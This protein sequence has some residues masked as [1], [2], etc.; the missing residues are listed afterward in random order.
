MKLKGI[1]PI[2]QHVEKIVLAVVGVVFV[3][4]LAVQFLV[5]PNEVNFEGQNVPPSEVLTRLGTKAS[6]TL[7]AMND[8]DPALPDA[9]SLDLAAAYEARLESAGF[10]ATRVARGG[11]GAPFELAIAQVEEMNG[12]VTPLRLPVATGAMAVSQW[13]TVD[14]FFARATPALQAYLPES[15]P[16]DKVSVSIEAKVNG[17][18]IREALESADEGRRSIPSHWWSQGGE[19][20]I[21][22]LSVEAERQ[23]RNAD[24]SWGPSEPVESI[25][26]TPDVLEAFN[27]G[28]AEGET[29]G[30]DA[31]RASDLLSLADLAKADPSLGAQPVFVPAISGVEWVQ[32]SKVSERQVRLGVEADIGRVEREIETINEEIARIQDRMAAAGA[33]RTA[34]SNRPQSSPQSGLIIGGGGG[35]QGNTNRANRPDPLKQRIDAKQA[36]IAEREAELDDLF[37]KL[38]DLGGPL[39][40]QSGQPRRQTPPAGGGGGARVLGGPTGA[41]SGP[42]VLGGDPTPGRSTS[43]ARGSRTRTPVSRQAGAESPGP[44]LSLDDYSVWVHDFAA[45]PGAVYRYRVRYGV[46]NPLFKRERSLGS[47][48]P[49]M[50]ALAEEPLVQS[51]W[52]SWTEPAQVG[53]SSYFFVTNARDQGILGQSSSAATAEVYRMFY[54]YYRKHTLSLEPGDAVQGEFRLPDDLP[55]FDV[56]EVSEDEL[57]AYFAEREGT[58]VPGRAVGAD[59]ADEADDGAEREWLTLVEPRYPLAV[60]AVMLDVSEYP[61]A[62][63]TDSQI[64]RGSGRV[65]EVLFFDPISGVVARRPDRD[66]ETSEYAAVQQSAGLAE[67]AKVRQPDLEYVP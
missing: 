50:L 22:V 11:F 53:R 63:G 25:R 27:E 47:E 65:L 59:P 19:G 42:I 21:E 1:N 24:G 66:R 26:W 55:L 44:L 9:G 36:E 13:A 8:T 46:N 48:D 61:V 17:Q 67:S 40:S 34:Q 15:Q 10:S 37:K 6:A 54:G 60:D 56:R 32:P 33:G 49:E 52:S 62:E 64:A 35:N 16:L 28:A 41:P 12:P 5:S 18:L 29:L 31:L 7:S 58:E 38:E 51:D 45:E 3:G 30:W 57:V 43:R 2:E 14:P 39:A 4:V 20:L 23:M